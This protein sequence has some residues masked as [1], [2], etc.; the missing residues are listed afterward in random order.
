MYHT[1]GRSFSL[2]QCQQAYA[3]MD[4]KLKRD[5]P[6]KLESIAPEYGL[7]E[8]EYPS[9]VRAY[10]FQMS[11]LSAADAVEGLVALLEAAKGIRLEIELEGGRGAG[12]W[13]GGAR[14]WS[15]DDKDANDDADP[16]PQ[17]NGDTDENGQRKE[18]VQQWHVPNF[19]IAY[20]ACD[21]IVRLRH[22]LTLARSLHCAI[23]RQGSAILDKAIIR[24]LKTFRFAAVREGPD[25]RV[26]AHP[27][28]L[29]RLALWLVDA[30]RDKWAERD[31]KHGHKVTSLPFVVACLNEDKGSY[32]V[33]GVTGAPE[34]GDVRKK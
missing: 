11:A 1:D 28:P 26:F 31:A 13:W 3:H 4:M 7:V 14:L 29:S 18:A 25:L 21:D 17:P 22:S 34:F 32:L 23:L 30:T 33:V 20:D 12:D 16:A 19:W 9:F 27:A 2:L 8:L 10:G 15:I 5:L 6:G 24:P